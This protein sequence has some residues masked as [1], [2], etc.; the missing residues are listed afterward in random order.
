ME[1]NQIPQESC[2]ELISYRLCSAAIALALKRSC[3][4]TPTWL[5]GFG[6]QFQAIVWNNTSLAL[7]RGK[8]I[9]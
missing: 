3:W 7:I 5:K 4:V 9:Q 8:F 1:E 2:S 6:E